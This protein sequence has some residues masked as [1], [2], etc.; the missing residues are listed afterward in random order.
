VY[1]RNRVPTR[2]HS[3]SITPYEKWYDRKPDI[4]HLNI[5]GCTAYAYIPDQLRQ[6]LDAKAEALVF[7]GYSTRSKGYRLYD[8]ATKKIVVRRDVVFDETLLGLPKPPQSDVDNSEKLTIDPADSD[9]PT[10]AEPS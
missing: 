8:P 6:K 1:V 5:F 7:V 10:T 4:G 9:S 3:G 2:A